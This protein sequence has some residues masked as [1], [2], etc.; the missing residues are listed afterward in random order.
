MK[1]VAI[2]ETEG[3]KLP[4]V[5]VRNFI[6]REYK[7]KEINSHLLGY[8]SEVNKKQLPKVSKKYKLG[9]FIGH[10]GIEEKFDKTL[11]GKD[12]YQ[13]IEVDAR[14]RVRKTI[15]ENNIYKGIKNKKAIPGNNIRLT[16]DR[17]LQLEASKATRR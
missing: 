7:D 4:G 9:D 5:F 2:I 11:R 12:G 15:L 14:G 3:T 1:E 6:S 16:I 17:D 10:S 13:F 8:I